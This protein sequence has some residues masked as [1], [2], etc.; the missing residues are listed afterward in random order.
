MVARSISRP[1]RKYERNLAFELP[2]LLHNEV[3]KAALA[4]EIA[5]MKAT[6]A[7]IDATQPGG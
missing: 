1:H 7:D 4:R 5:C 6:P 3:R 2:V